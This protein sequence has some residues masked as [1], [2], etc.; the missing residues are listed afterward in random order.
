MQLSSLLRGRV[1]A[2]AMLIAVT[3]M[4]ACGILPTRNNSLTG[5]A[6]FSQPVALKPGSNIFVVNLVDVSDQSGDQS[7]ISTYSSKVATPPISFAIQYDPA[8][9]DPGH[10]YELMAK[11]RDAKGRVLFESADSYPVLTKGNPKTATILL[12]PAEGGP[13]AASAQNKIRN[14]ID[15]DVSAIKN[16]LGKLRRVAGK[17]SA[18]EGDTTFEAFVSDDGTPVL[19]NESRDLGKYGTSDV[20]FYFRNGELLRF[21]EQATRQGFGSNDPKKPLHY[22]LKLDFAMGHFAVGSKT[23]N[24][25]ASKPDKHEISSAI[26]QAKVARTRVKAVLAE[27]ELSEPKGRQTFVCDDQGSFYATFNKQDENVRIEFL[28]RDPIILPQQ[29]VASGFSYGDGTRELRGKGQNAT[30]TGADGHKTGCTVSAE[31]GGLVLAPGDF[32]VVTMKSLDQ[33]DNKE[34]TRKLADLMPAIKACLRRDVGDLPSVLKAWPMSHGTVG[35]RTININGGRY[36][37]LAPA[38]GLGDIHTEQ[39]EGPTNI[40]PGERDVRFTPASGAYPDGKCFEHKR[41]EKDGVFIGWL[42]RNSCQS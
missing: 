41:L 35:V 1:R 23:I 37:C 34:W 36:D 20:S 30:W 19:V 9:I 22:N 15:R 17:Y 13:S 14:D 38:T 29:R 21:T 27:T 25:Q 24:G 11:I 7:V 5:T 31:I 28:G 33:A 32:P 40:L 26:T 18:D 39:V 42:S 12:Q 16:Q 8:R 4:S 2:C 10:N 6:T 3:A